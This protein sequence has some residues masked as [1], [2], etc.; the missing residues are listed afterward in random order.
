MTYRE[1]GPC[2]LGLRLIVVVGPNLG[3]NSETPIS[4]QGGGAD[5]SECS[6]GDR[7]ESESPP[8]E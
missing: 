7:D 5:T 3:R 8:E 4:S 6:N 2:I 1:G